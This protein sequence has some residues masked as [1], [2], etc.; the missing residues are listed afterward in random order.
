[1]CRSNSR[2]EK[3]TPIA[4]CN[5]YYTLLSAFS[6]L[7]FLPLLSTTPNCFQSGMSWKILEVSE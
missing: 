6:L 5:A 7:S 4:V 2:S 1:M 3:H